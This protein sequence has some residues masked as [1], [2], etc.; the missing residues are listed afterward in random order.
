MAGILCGLLVPL[1]ASAGDLKQVVVVV[2][3]PVPACE[4]HLTHFVDRLAQIGEEHGIDIDLTTIRANGDRQFAENQLSKILEKGR[5]DAVA[6]IATLASKAA[7]T[8]FKDT[9]VPIFFFQVTD[10]VGAGLA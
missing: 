9:G 6:T 3:M 10:P 7:V 2:T 8:V 5:P 1:F 4:T